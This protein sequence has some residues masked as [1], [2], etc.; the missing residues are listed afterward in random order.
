MQHVEGGLEAVAAIIGCDATALIDTM[1]NVAAAASN[2]DGLGRCVF[3][4]TM[5]L[6]SGWYVARIT[7]VVHYTMGGVAVDERARV[8]REDGEVIEGLYA[9]GEAAG[10]VHG[11][12]RLGGNSLLECAVFGRVAGLEAGGFCEGSTT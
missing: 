5:D 4:D 11:G 12:N 6:A 1:H 9:A 2:T 10:G 8:L 3:P 7:P